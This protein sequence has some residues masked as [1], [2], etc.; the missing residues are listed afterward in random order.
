MNVLSRLMLLL[1]VLM[2]CAGCKASTVATADDAVARPGIVCGFWREIRPSRD[3]RMTLPT[4]EQILG[5]N[6]AR[7]AAG[8]PKE[9][10]PPKPEPK[11]QTVK[12]AEK[13][14]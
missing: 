12:V 7:E 2:L 4:A 14:T 8:C 1:A 6:K 9:S 3:D 10:P 5:N 13:A 11:R